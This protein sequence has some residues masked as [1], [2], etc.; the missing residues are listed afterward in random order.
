MTP[1]IYYDMPDSEYFAAPGL[2]QSGLKQFARTPAH[3]R[4]SMERTTTALNFGK[5]YHMFLLEPKRVNIECAFKPEGF[6]GR[7]IE[8]KTWM[9]ENEQKFIVSVDEQMD[10]LAMLARFRENETARSLL[11]KSIKEVSIFWM[12]P[13]FGF[14]C[15]AR[16]DL[17]CM[18]LK[19]AADLK[20]T[21]ATVDADTFIRESQKYGYHI[22]AWWYLRGLKVLTGEDFSFLAVPQEKKPIYGV[23]VFKISEAK[24]AEAQGQIMPLLPAYAK[25]L[26]TDVWPAYPDCVQDI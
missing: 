12:D 25:C 23:A 24:L 10:L 7:K 6:D 13:D 17:L 4:A 19:I 22:Q 5:V 18:A 11:K 14:M 26:E 8:G 1:G 20:T 16:I 9:K 2:S 15:K 21:K 3:Y